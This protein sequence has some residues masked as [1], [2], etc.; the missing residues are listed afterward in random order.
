M[1]REGNSL[2][3]VGVP[4]MAL[5]LMIAA[6]VVRFCGQRARAGGSRGGCEQVCSRSAASLPRSG[7][8]DVRDEDLPK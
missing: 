5:A 4:M 6:A 8:G 7:P 2:L 1:F 3:K